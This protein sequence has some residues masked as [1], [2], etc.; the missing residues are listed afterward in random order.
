M[1]WPSITV[2]EA[3]TRSAGAGSPE[4]L[5]VTT[6]GSTTDVAGADSEE[7]PAATADSGATAANARQLAPKSV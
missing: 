3:A 7:V 1:A 6:S 2:T 4:R 5:A